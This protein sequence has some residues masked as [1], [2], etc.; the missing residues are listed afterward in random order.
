[1]E[2]KEIKKRV[3]EIYAGMEAFK[4]ELKDIRENICKHEETHEGLYQ[5]G[6]SRTLL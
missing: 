2:K 4:D 6:G 1:M 3:K 5:W